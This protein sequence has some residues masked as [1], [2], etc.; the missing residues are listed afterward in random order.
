MQEEE[1]RSVILLSSNIFNIRVFQNPINCKY[2]SSSS[3]GKGG[4]F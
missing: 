4:G 3:Y 1:N 2:G